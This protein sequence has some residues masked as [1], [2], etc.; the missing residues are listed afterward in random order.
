MHY[1]HYIMIM[2]KEL[3]SQLLLS[4]LRSVYDKKLFSLLLQRSLSHDHDKKYISSF[5]HHYVHYADIM[6]KN[7]F[8]HCYCVH[9]N[10]IITKKN[11]FFLLLLRSVRRD[12]DKKHIF[13]F[14]YHYIHYAEILNK[15]IFPHC[16]YVHYDLNIAT[17]RAHHVE[18]TS[19]RHR[20]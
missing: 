18:S 11:F 10:V 14:Q 17:Q 12:H 19:I 2:K 5:Q 9:H 20:Y 8:S 16:Y 6:N 3:F 1:I 15:N 7:I 13:S 4:P